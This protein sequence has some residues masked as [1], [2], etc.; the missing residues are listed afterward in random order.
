MCCCNNP[1]D[2]YVVFVM[3]Y[4]K[5]TTGREN[6]SSRVTIPY[7]PTIHIILPKSGISEDFL[8][9]VGYSGLLRHVC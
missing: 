2:S 3:G 8:E 7:I 6:A 5:I 9:V 4:S 1:K